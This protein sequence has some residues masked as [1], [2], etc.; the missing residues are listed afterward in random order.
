[1]D[2]RDLDLRRLTYKQ[3]WDE[4]DLSLERR[5]PFTVDA[6]PMRCQ[7]GFYMAII[8]IGLTDHLTF[9]FKRLEQGMEVTN[10]FLAETEALYPEEYALAEEI[11]EFISAEMNFYLPP[12]EIG[13]IAL[14]IH[15]ATNLKDVLEVNRHHQLVGLIASHIE[16]RLEIKID[17]KSL[18]YKRLI[19]HLRSA[20]EWVSHGEYLEAPEKVEKILREEYPLCYDSAWEL[21]S[22][23]ER[24]LKK[25]VP[26]GEATYL[27]MHL[28]RLVQ[29]DSD[30]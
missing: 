18:D 10:P 22:I 9:T 8:H 16:Q 26:R 2:F 30:K 23:M 7:T 5:D 25:A 19:R 6:H 24:Q 4:D 28:Q 15:S 21:M 1:M 11:V 17:R 13:F 27:T 3:S 14:H 29:Y 20:I 12:A